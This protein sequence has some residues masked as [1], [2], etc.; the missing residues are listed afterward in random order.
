MG[1]ATY[2]GTGAARSI[3]TGFKPDFVWLKSRSS[4]SYSHNLYDAVRGATKILYSDSTS[5]ENTDANGLTAFNSDGFS[6]GSTA[7]TNESS[8][9]YVAWAWKAGGNSNTFNINDV[10]YATASAAGLTA[11]TITPTGASV[12]TKSGFSIVKWNGSGSSGTLS[13]GLGNTP[14]LILLKG[15]SSGEGSNN[16]RTYHSALGTS[17]SNTLFLNLTNASS[18]NTER[19]SAV[20]TNTFTLSSGGSGVNESGQ[21]YI[22]YLWAEIPG[23]SKFGTYTGNASSN[24]PMIVTGFRPRF[25]LVKNSQNTDGWS[26]WDAARDP[27]NEVIYKIEPNSSGAEGSNSVHKF[28]FL[29]NGFKVRGDWA[30]IN[31][32][33][34]T[35]IYAAFAET[36]TQN[37]YGAQANAR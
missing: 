16:W 13:H 5:S 29:S 28:D 27:Y 2:T 18:S 14:G 37:L 10:G 21:S 25:L 36:P 9:T 12:N 11:G 31:G 17:P 20:G 3:N 24:G 1:V 33:G 19:I 32:S 7:A 34:N 35:I 6:L 23:F 15:T 4:G 8:T 26:M 30:G 22:S